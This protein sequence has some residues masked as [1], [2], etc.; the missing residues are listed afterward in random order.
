MPESSFNSARL[1][2]QVIF[3]QAS[4]RQI[5]SGLP[6][7]RLRLIAQSRAPSSHLPNLP[8]LMCSGTQEI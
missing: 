6:Q 4:Q 5:G 8:S 3:P 1:P 2:I 7:Y